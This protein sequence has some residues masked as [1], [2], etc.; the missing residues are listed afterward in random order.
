MKFEYLNRPTQWNETFTKYPHGMTIFESLASWLKQNDKM[1][2]HINNWTDFIDL[3]IK[4]YR[5]WHSDFVG[6]W[7][8]N[9]EK[10]VIKTL[11][12]WQESGFLEVVI[13]EALQ[14][15]MDVLEEETHTKLEDFETQLAETMTHLNTGFHRVT[16]LSTDTTVDNLPILQFAIDTYQHILIPRGVYYINI[17]GLQIPSNRIIEFEQGSCLKALPHNAE[18]YELL[19]IVNKHNIKIIGGLLDGN[20]IENTATNGEW[21]MGISIKGSNKIEVIKTHIKNCW[22]DGVY[23]GSSTSQTY[24][25]N[26][27]IDVFCDNNRR[28]GISL[29]SGKN[30][31]ICGELINT[32][33][34]DPSAGLDIEP[35]DNNEFLENI[36]I[37]N[38]ITQ[39]NKY[40][41]LVHLNG[42]S[43]GEN[44]K[45]VNIKIINHIDKGSGN[46]ISI[47]K[48]SDKGIIKG[49]IEVISPSWIKSRYASVIC[50]D[51]FS[52]SIKI[53]IMDP[54]IIEPNTSGISNSRYN[55]TISF[56]RDASSD[57]PIG[58]FEIINMT[59]TSNEETMNFKCF[60]I[61]DNV[62]DFKIVNPIELS[63][64]NKIDI[65]QTGVTVLDGNKILK[66]S[67]S[68]SQTLGYYEYSTIVDNSIA[69]GIVTLTL[70][71]RIGVGFPPIKLVASNLIH[72]LDFK[73]EP[74]SKILGYGIAGQRM[75]LSP[76]SSVTLK[77]LDSTTWIVVELVGQIT[78]Q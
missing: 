57:I 58:N 16:G 3:F 43:K 44:I 30:I 15:Q 56:W 11:M 53:K 50:R 4:E 65:R 23:I 77:R 52:N 25:E 70:D 26:V 18:K 9:L 64:F 10:E 6:K 38:L 46:N 12:D 63:G 55:S 69:S 22:G 24:C 1:V 42:L 14:T 13:D 48:P 60:N 78:A 27:V 68:G 40:G 32:N 47:E 19:N 59:I 33:G 73:T 51:W 45:N 67:I 34:T 71:D 66:R 72:P 62:K 49:I 20:R 7:D 76:G 21:G 37:N 36:L 41:I 8:K 39:N 74:N 2:D 17:V 29:I 31:K 54:I 75:R 61:D 28:Q 35:N 5:K